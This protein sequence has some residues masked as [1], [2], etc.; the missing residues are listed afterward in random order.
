MFAMLNIQIINKCIYDYFYNREFLQ[1]SFV[2]TC[3]HKIQMKISKVYHRN[4]QRICIKV[5]YDK[6]IVAKIKQVSDAKWSRTM[7]AW[8]I[9]YSQKSYNDLKAMFPNV[10]IEGKKKKENDSDDKK[11]ISIIKRNT[12]KENVSDKKVF[13]S[14]DKQ[15]SEIEIQYTHARIFVKLPKKDTDTQFLKTFK[16]VRWDGDRFLW[17]IPNFGKN[18][19]ILLSYFKGRNVSVCELKSIVIEQRKTPVYSAA[20]NFLVV[21]K[22][23]RTLK[24]YFAYNRAL[25]NELKQLQVCRWSVEEGCW[26]MPYSDNILEKLHSICDANGLVWELKRES[27][28]QGAPRKFVEN[29]VK[30]PVNYVEKLK[31]LRYSK[32]TIETYTDLFEEFINYYL[33]KKPEDISEEEIVQFL[34]YLVNERQ[35]STSYQNQSI[36]AI[37]FFYERVLGGIRKIYEIERPRKEQYLP[38]VLSEEE[39]AAILK[40]ITNIKHKALIMTIYSGGLRISEVINLKVKD[41]DSKRM[42]IRVT[43]AKVHPVGL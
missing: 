17:I 30:C 9:P 13:N 25:I 19:D 24:V 20:G 37:K 31:E 40:S 2:I 10:E 18:L 1:H 42:Q 38:E 4:E 15:N 29:P 34:R 14:I 16:Y 8:H 39:V 26:T 22:F 32:N 43:Q 33:P 5:D 3:M 27:K 35:I 12:N 23:N 7:N 6:D 11:K 28:T 36:N 41:I 21:N